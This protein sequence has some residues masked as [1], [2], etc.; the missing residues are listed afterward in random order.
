MTKTKITFILLILCYSCTN[1]TKDSNSLNQQKQIKQ[2][3]TNVTLDKINIDSE[4]QAYVKLIKEDSLK[5]NIDALIPI[6]KALKK[7]QL[8]D[9]QI[10]LFLKS[11]DKLCNTNVEYS[12]F[13]NELL[14][15]VLKW[16]PNK[17]ITI[18]EANKES[19]D[20][21]YIVEELKSPIHDE[22]DVKGTYTKVLNTNINNE[23][24]SKILYSLDTAKTKFE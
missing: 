21:N 11:F 6:V 4:Y 8:T 18:L 14:F 12:E 24:K 13:S 19:I 5:C 23:F 7:K 2:D 9:K 16:Y 15:G 20:I 3:I 10:L 22:I 17:V 1:N